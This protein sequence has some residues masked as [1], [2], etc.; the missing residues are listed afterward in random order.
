MK[1]LEYGAN[2]NDYWQYEYMITQLEDCVEK[3]AFP[4]FDFV[5]LFDHSS[6]HDQM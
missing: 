4:T 1:E 6:G 5:F 3:C 2:N